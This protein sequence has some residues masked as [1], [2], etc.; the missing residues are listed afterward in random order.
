MFTGSLVMA[1]IFF[2]I[3]IFLWCRA[4]IKRKENINTEKD[5][6]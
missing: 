2:T 5:N 1:G 4:V 6:L 3:G